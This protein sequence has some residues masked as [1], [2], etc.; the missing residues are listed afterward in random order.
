M[1]PN[2][3]AIVIVIFLI[4]CWVLYIQLYASLLG[5]FW[6]AD[7]SFCKETELDMF[8]VY[9]D[10]DVDYT[11]ARACYVLALQEGKMIINDPAKVCISFDLLNIENLIPSAHTPK[12]FD[13]HFHNLD[14]NTL[15]VFPEKQ[16]LK[17][18]PLCCKIVL[19]YDD[20]VTAVLYKNPVNTELRSLMDDK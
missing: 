1:Y 3:F 14:E 8:C 10:V 11:N 17:F 9:F 4:V 18:Y 6:E 12:H 5:G 20:V 2:E 19:Y 15:E 13:V 7:S 16:K